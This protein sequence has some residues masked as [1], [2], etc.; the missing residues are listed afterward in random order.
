MNYPNTEKH[1]SEIMIW[2]KYTEEI[3]DRLLHL[4]IEMNKIHAQWIFNKLNW[5]QNQQP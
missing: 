2:E 5:I 1:F 3:L 4:S